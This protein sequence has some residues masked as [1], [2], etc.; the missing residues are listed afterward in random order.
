MRHP[1]KAVDRAV[2]AYNPKP[3]AWCLVDGARFKIWVAT[4]SP[5]V[6]AA[7]GE[8]RLIEG[9]VILGSRTGSLELIEVQPAGRPVMTAVAWMNGRRAEPAEL[10]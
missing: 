7:P 1:A 10:R 9:R 6:A 3:G 8:A 4:R 2:R 5:G